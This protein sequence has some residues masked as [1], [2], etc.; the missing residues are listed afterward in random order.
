[1]SIWVYIY[2]SHSLSISIIYTSLSSPLLPPKLR[3]GLGDA[4][5]IIVDCGVLNPQVVNSVDPNF[6]QTWGR[7]WAQFHHIFLGIELRMR[8]MEV[9]W[10]EWLD[11]KLMESWWKLKS[12]SFRLMMK[13]S[14][15]TW[16][17]L[18]KSPALAMALAMAAMALDSPG[19]GRSRR[20]AFQKQRK[21]RPL[22]GLESLEQWNG[23][24][25]GAM[26]R[27][28]RWCQKGLVQQ[29]GDNTI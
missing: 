22:R 16:I 10:D 1:M 13:W 4:K 12:Q 11:G 9:S 5:A 17:H 3:P 26:G 29:W 21:E 2:H 15:S 28:F 14:A 19:E 20:Q 7:N 18:P 23:G 24:D 6:D 25:R 27:P 8:L